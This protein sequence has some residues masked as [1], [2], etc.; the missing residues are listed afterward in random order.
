[1]M[2]AMNQYLFWSIASCELI[3]VAVCSVTMKLFY[4]CMDDVAMG[5][6]NHESGGVYNPIV[7]CIS[8]TV[9]I[10]AFKLKPISSRW[11]QYV[12][13]TGSRFIS[14]KSVD[15]YDDDVSW[16]VDSYAKLSLKIVKNNRSTMHLRWLAHQFSTFGCSNGV[17]LHLTTMRL[18]FILVALHVKSNRQED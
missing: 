15:G 13:S 17:L 9:T 4:T 6:Q 5:R 11:C 18:K 10:I 12:Y 16:L 8:L 2:G 14:I 7:N 1:M 3:A